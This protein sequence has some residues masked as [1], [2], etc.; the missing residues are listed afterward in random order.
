MSHRIAAVLRTREALVSGRARLWVDTR[1]EAHLL[2]VRAGLEEALGALPQADELAP[3]DPGDA[4]VLRIDL[5]GLTPEDAQRA[6]EAVDATGGVPCLTPADDPGL[7]EALDRGSV[8][9]DHVQA[10][11]RARQ[12]LDADGRAVPLDLFRDPTPDPVL[13]AAAADVAAALHPT[14]A[15]IGAVRERHTGRPGLEIRIDHGWDEDGDVVETRRRSI[16]ESLYDAVRGRADHALLQLS[17]DVSTVHHPSGLQAVVWVITPWGPALPGDAGLTESEAVPLDSLAVDAVQGFED[18]EVQVVPRHANDHD[19]VVAT[20]TATARQ[21]GWCGG[22]S[23]WVAGRFAPTWRAPVGT[24]PAVGALRA[25]DGVLGVRVVPGEPRGLSAAWPCVDPAWRSR[26]GRWFVRWRDARTGRDLLPRV[27]PRTANARDIDVAAAIPADV[28][29]I[30]DA[31]G[32]SGLSVEVHRSECTDAR[33][34]ALL[35]TTSGPAHA[36]LLSIGGLGAVPTGMQVRLWY[37]NDVG[38]G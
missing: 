13:A 22:R 16:L 34:D 20:A 4:W 29:P 26:G 11:V 33:L 18:L 15:T 10:G 32:A 23:R 14:A 25:L 24:V 21:Q 12:L 30:A 6:F 35:A 8:V 31:R 37:R 3:W 27:S 38:A 7:T 17:P 28:V 5:P 9:D 2:R 36:E 19:A 1:D